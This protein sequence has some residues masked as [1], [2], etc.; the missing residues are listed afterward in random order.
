MDKDEQTSRER[1]MEPV[2]RDMGTFVRPV[3]F[4]FDK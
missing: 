3:L 2:F 4:S 1:D